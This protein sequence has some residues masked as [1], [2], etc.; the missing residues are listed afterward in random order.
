QMAVD[1]KV[2]LDLGYAGLGTVAE[3]HHVCPMHP[4]YAEMPPQEVNPEKARQMM[5]EAGLGDFEHE[6]ISIDDDWLRNSTDAV[7]DQL[8]QAGIKVK[9]T[10]LPGSTFWNDWTK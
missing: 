1:N 7:A 5:E 10:I 3:N 2:C 6:I 8:R 4:E 9:R